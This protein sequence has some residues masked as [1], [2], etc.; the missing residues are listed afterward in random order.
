MNRCV[1]VLLV[2][3]NED[4]I[5]LTRKALERSQE[6]DDPVEL[7]VHV[8]M[9]GVAAIDFINKRAPHEGAPTP[10]LILLD[11][12][13]PNKNGFEVLA[14]VKADARHRG[15]PVVMLT[16][17]DAEVDITNSYNLGSNSYI[18]KPIETDELFKK[19]K[20]IPDYWVK[21]NTLP[22]KPE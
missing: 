20:N 4:H 17:S 13:L 16:S 5:F 8:V 7:R 10:D 11:I 1:D 9:D 21:T 14:S 12:K 2:E 18:T 6:A 22:P 15:I 19:L 3:D